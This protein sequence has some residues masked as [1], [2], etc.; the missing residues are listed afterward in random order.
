MRSSIELWWS[1]MK[2]SVGSLRSPM[3]AIRTIALAAEGQPGRRIGRSRLAKGICRCNE[4]R[5]HHHPSVTHSN[6]RGNLLGGLR[7]HAG[8]DVG[9]LS[10]RE[11]WALVA[12]TFADHLYRDA[13]T[14]RKRGMSVSQVVVMPSSA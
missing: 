12:E 5:G 1:V 7:L 6:Q 11:R 9:V 10:E 3:S 13:G 2:P 4:T 8:H 14:E